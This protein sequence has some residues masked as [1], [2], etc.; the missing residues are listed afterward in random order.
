LRRQAAFLPHATRL[1]LLLQLAN[2]LPLPMPR[3]IPLQIAILV[4]RMSL[5]QQSLYA[6][7]FANLKAALKSLW[8]TLNNPYAKTFAGL[9][10]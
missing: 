7:I 6:I 9:A 8:A 10:I 2:R 5:A 4:V 3:Q 1:P